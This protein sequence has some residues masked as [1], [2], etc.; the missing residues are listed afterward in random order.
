MSQPGRSKYTVTLACL[1]IVS[2]TCV[3]NAQAL[4][5]GKGMPEFERICSSCHT[6]AMSTRLNKSRAEW[7]SIVNDMVSRG[8]QG[9]QSDLDSVVVYLTANFGADKQRAATPAVSQPAATVAEKVSE[10]PLTQPEIASAKETLKK[11]NCLTCHRVENEGSYRGPNLSSIGSHRTVEQIRAALVTPNPVVIP[12]NRTVRLV[13]HEGK[14]VSGKILNQD[15]FTVQLIDSSGQL[16]TL[17]K[18]G[19]KEFSIVDTNPMPSYDNKM[20]A[21]EL[22]NLL[23]YLG[24][25]KDPDKQ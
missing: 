18:S 14:N 10:P 23:R 8:A 4:P 13:T 5:D 16:S 6:V 21:Q 7:T 3:S 11:N 9:S 25:L 12:E 1:L 20:S 19:L 24:S 22:T 17:R 2:A 15:G